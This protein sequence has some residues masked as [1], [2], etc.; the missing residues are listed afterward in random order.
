MAGQYK[1]ALAAARLGR[2][3]RHGEAGDEGL[4]ES[5]RPVQD[6]TPEEIREIRLRANASQAIFA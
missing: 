4:A 5:P 3:R 2:D 1:R 6:M